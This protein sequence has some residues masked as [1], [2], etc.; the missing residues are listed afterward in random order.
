MVLDAGTVNPS[1]ISWER[2]NRVGEVTVYESTPP[3]RVIER[4]GDAPIIVC[5]RTRI[6]REVFEQCP[7]LK[8]VGLF[9]TGYNIIDTA[10]AKEHG[11][12]V[13]NVPGYSTEA[14]AQFVFALLLEICHHV[15]AYDSLVRTGRWEE[16]PGR[17]ASALPLM[18]LK[19]KTMGIIG[20][21]DI[22]YRTAQIAAAFGMRVLGTRRHPDP[23]METDSIR[24][25]DLDT[26]LRESDVISLH[27]PLFPETRNLIDKAAIAKMKDGAILI[28]TARGPILNERD[29][30][31]ALNSGKLW[32]AGVDVLSNEPP[33]EDNP[34]LH[35]KNCI[36]TPHIAWA[37][38]ETRRRLVRMVAENMEAFLSGCPIHVV[39]P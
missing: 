22:G 8:Y 4:I 16:A 39:N 38:E 3:E 34:L 21:G 32:G 31:D 1:D 10:A 7:G 35:T 13:C 18:E 27:C 11:V 37:P 33:R 15:P 6:R 26:L 24:F 36:V 12:V 19:D 28:N 30:A 5:T 29:V 9:A 17:Y 14:V 25:T 2:L 23:R 20:M